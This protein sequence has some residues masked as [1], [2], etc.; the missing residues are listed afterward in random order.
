MLVG[1]GFIAIIT[2]AVAQRFV[3][4]G[5]TTEIDTAELETEY[6]I[7]TVEAHVLGELRDL[8]KS[9]RRSRGRGQTNGPGAARSVGQG[10]ER[11][12]AL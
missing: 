12:Q 5:V 8:P 10:P 1:I 2:A 11:R 4:A 9:T 3:V 6:D 7:E